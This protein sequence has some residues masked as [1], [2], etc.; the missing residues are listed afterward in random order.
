MHAWKAIQQVVDHI[1]TH[2]TEDISIEALATIAG[3]SLY[4]L[5]RLFK[6]I[7]NKTLFEYIRLRRLAQAAEALKQNRR[8]IDVSVEYGFSSHANFTRAFKQAYGITPEEYRAQSISLNQMNKPD[9][10]LGY[11]LLDENVPLLTDGIVIEIT[12]KHLAKPEVYHGLTTQVPIA[13]QIPVGKTT[14]I[15]TPFHL[16][17]RFHACKSKLT[18]LSQNGVEL[19][20]SLPGDIKNGTFTY[21]AGASASRT[22]P[23]GEGVTRWELPAGDYI[24]CLLEAETAHELRTSA[25]DKGLNYL[26]GTWL[27]AH[28]QI[29]QAFSAEKYYAATPDGVSMSIWAL[30]APPEISGD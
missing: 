14:G 29:P 21:F 18:G 8:I 28:N 19:G 12:R 25:L 16:W 20:A 2:T 22:V 1:E 7:V 27:P 26:F 5:Q 3:L 30:L 4:Y 6:R 23:A 17:Q 11:S 10:R 15:D 13:G 24:V 9:V